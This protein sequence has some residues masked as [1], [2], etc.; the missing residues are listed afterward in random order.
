MAPIAERNDGTASSLSCRI[1]FV[2]DPAAVQVT[3]GHNPLTANGPQITN[4]LEHL[5]RKVVDSRVDPADLFL[6]ATA[7]YNA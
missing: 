2:L 5:P 7:A 4:V 1:C 3:R 6:Q